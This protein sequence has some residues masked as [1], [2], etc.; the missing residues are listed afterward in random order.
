M[1]KRI[2]EDNP[3]DDGMIDGTK[4]GLNRPALLQYRRDSMSPEAGHRNQ[5][6]KRVEINAQKEPKVIYTSDDRYIE[7]ANWK[8]VCFTLHFPNLRWS[9]NI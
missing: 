5:F 1:K 6:F 8:P 4:D 2:P 7:I 3:P 9:T